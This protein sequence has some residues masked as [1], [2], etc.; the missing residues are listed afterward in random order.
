MWI[1]SVPT[2]DSGMFSMMNFTKGIVARL[3]SVLFV[4]VSLGVIFF[5]SRKEKK[6]V[7]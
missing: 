2:Y 4:P 5:F 3:M 6:S 1:V 7:R